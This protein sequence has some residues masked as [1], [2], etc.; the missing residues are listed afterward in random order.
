MVVTVQAPP[1]PVMV[2]QVGVIVNL[3]LM[4]SNKMW[5]VCIIC[6]SRTLQQQVITVTVGADYQAASPS[7]V[8]VPA[9]AVVPVIGQDPKVLLAC[10][11]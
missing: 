10:F 6:R 11:K 1:Q 9:G 5:R 3:L 4:P 7:E 2:Q 8:S